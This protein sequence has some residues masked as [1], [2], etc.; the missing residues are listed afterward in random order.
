MVLLD[1]TGVGDPILDD[2]QNAFVSVEGYKFTNESK[3]RLVKQLQVAIEQRLITFPE[4]DVLM[5]ELME[6]EYGITK[7]GQVSYSAPHGKHDDCV[8]SLALAV[9]GIKSYIAAAQTIERR[10]DEDN[11]EYE[12]QTRERG[13]C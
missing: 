3:N 13:T 7:T 5:K 11:P 12:R 10:I 9:W 1:S 4:I 8:I 6:F 2:L